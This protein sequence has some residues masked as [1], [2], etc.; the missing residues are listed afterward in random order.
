MISSAQNPASVWLR[1]RT[2][3]VLTEYDG[4]QRSARREVELTPE[5]AT[6]RACPVGEVG[7]GLL[8]G[9]D[10]GLFEWQPPADPRLLLEGV[11]PV[12]LDPTG[13]TVLCLGHGTGELVLYD[14]EHA[15]HRTVPKPEG[16]RWPTFEAVFSPDGAWLAVDLDYSIE[17]SDEE[18]GEQLEDVIR[19]RATY[20]PTAWESSGA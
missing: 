1:A 12:T 4:K 10:S 13:R 7:S 16:G 11:R 17:D 14:V 3:P 18:L 2:R 8:L 15:T 9:G 20:E 5:L 6:Q 19:G